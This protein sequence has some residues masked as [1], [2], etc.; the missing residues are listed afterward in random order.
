MFTTGNIKRLCNRYGRL[1][2]LRNPLSNIVSPQSGVIKRSYESITIKKMLVM[3]VNVSGKSFV[4]PEKEQSRFKYG[5]IVELGEIRVIFTKPNFAISSNTI[6]VIDN[7]TFAVKDIIAS[8]E[9]YDILFRR[10]DDIDLGRQ[11]IRPSAS[12]EVEKTL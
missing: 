10:V 6:L 8:L 2:I 4:T 3:P 12:I 7:Y 9:Y 1:A 11:T 5:G